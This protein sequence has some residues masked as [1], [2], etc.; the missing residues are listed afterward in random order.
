MELDIKTMRVANVEVSQ[1]TFTALCE[2][3]KVEKLGA[4]INN[5]YTVEMVGDTLITPCIIQIRI[6]NI[7]KKDLSKTLIPEEDIADDMLFSP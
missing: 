1:K 6:K 7:Y 2:Y 4:K 3:I 5:L